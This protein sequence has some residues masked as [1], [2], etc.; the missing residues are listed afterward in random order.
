[1]VPVMLNVIESSFLDQA[2]R[3]GGRDRVNGFPGRTTHCHRESFIRSTTV[4]PASR[5]SVT[6]A[7]KRRRHSHRPS[8][9]LSAKS[10][11]SSL[12]LTA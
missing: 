2:A 10:F 7:M 5:C 11:A 6:L 3:R 8:R 4:S 1:V 9:Q 12:P